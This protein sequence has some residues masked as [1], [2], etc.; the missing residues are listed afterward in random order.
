MTILDPMALWGIQG[1]SP[2]QRDALIAAAPF[3]LNALKTTSHNIACLSASG[4]CST[5][6]EWQAVVDMAIQMAEAA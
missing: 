4:K 5:Y 6:N 1:M 2:A 3:L